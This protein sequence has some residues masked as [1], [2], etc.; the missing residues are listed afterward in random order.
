MKSILKP[1]EAAMNLVEVCCQQTA[2]IAGRVEIE[3]E[4]EIIEAGT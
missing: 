2:F 4:I 3:K 1:V